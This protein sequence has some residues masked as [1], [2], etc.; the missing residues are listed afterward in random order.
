M[1]QRLT[2]KEIK[3]DEFTSVMGRGVEYAE[4]HV[5]TLIYAL[6]AVVVAALIAFAAYLLL[7]S[8]AEKANEALARAVKI[9][10]AP[11][12]ATAAKPDDAN[13]PSFADEAARRT[14]ARKLLEEVRDDYGMSDAADVAGLYLAQIAVAEG[15]LDQARELWTEFVDDHGDSLL[16]G[17]A[18][19]NLIR[20]DRQQ[21]KGQDLAQRLKT[22]LEEQEPPLPKDVILNE[23]GETLEQLGRREEA[24]QAYRQ[25]VDDYPQSRYRSDA[26]QKL[27]ALDPTRAAGGAGNAMPSI[28]GFPGS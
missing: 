24:A 28:P 15:K 23:L 20:L 27:S 12:D 4:T 9:Y 18:R 19:I 10:N 26:Q 16:A 22:M 2:R 25:I 17:A 1:S 6:G 21:G 8:R 7:G 5:R 11:I 14:R 3:R 13:A